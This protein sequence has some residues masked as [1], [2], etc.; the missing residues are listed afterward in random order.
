MVSSRLALAEL[1]IEQ[2]RPHEA[3]E[4]ACAA[5][6]QYGKLEQIDSQAKAWAVF[7]RSLLEQGKVEPA[8]AAGQQAAVL[9]G[10]GSNPGVRLS[11]AVYA[12]RVRAVSD[13]AGAVRDLRAA[14]GEATKLGLVP[15]RL[16]ASA[17]LG[18]VEIKSGK[19]GA[20]R[21]RLGTVRAEAA[22]KGFG[23]VARRASLALQR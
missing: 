20:G 21:A 3:E 10:K 22:A 9:A 16:E 15:M 12:A 23:L 17:A 5:A 8:A 19:A 14:L 4:P 11:V 1:S 7:T 13:A 6:E 2:G 18:E